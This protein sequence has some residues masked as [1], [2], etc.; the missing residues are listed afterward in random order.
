MQLKASVPESKWQSLQKLPMTSFRV[1][2]HLSQENQLIYF[3]LKHSQFVEYVMGF[4]W[5]LEKAVSVFQ[6]DLFLACGSQIDFD[7][8][9]SLQTWGKTFG[10]AAEVVWTIICSQWYP[11]PL[12]K[13]HI[14]LINCWRP[15]FLRTISLDPSKL[16][17]LQLSQWQ[18]L[19]NNSLETYCALNAA[20][21]DCDRQFTIWR[22]FSY[23]HS[24]GNFTAE[25]SDIPRQLWNMWVWPKIT[26][27]LVDSACKLRHFKSWKG[28]PIIK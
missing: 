13:W 15:A 1:A 19:V 24:G 8:C 25:I 12:G 11:L 27:S 26:C 28:P 5:Q 7:P 23:V 14:P 20:V 16:L 3:Y 2:A 21:S 6:L 10:Y 17:L 18:A 9:Q 22:F 4:V